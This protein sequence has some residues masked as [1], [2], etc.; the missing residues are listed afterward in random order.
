MKSL[1]KLSGIVLIGLYCFNAA[2]AQTVKVD[3]KAAKSA[4]IAKLI[5]SR[6]Y[7]FRADRATPLRGGNKQLT[8]EYDVTISKDK[9]VIY[10]PY[11]GRAY[12]APMDATDG[13]IK[14][15]S[16]HFDYKAEQGKKGDWSITIKPKEKNLSGS[17][18]VQLLRLSSSADG[19]ASLQVTCLN[20]DA[21]SFSGYIE[22]APKE[23]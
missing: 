3:K 15:T 20:R 4:E 8:S 19:Y 12:S 1:I 10:L 11:Y 13:G 18:D 22:E 14:L 2:N 23:K 7:I 6:N 21:I 17:K 5:N 16:T 9:I